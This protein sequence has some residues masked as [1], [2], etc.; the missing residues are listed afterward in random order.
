MFSE[1]AALRYFLFEVP[2]ALEPLRVLDTR[3]L[4]WNGWR[5]RLHILGASHAVCMERD[6]GQ[7]TE[8]LACIAPSEQDTP[9]WLGGAQTAWETCLVIQGL[10]CRIGLSPVA[11]HADIGLEAPYTSD[12][13][14][15]AAYPAASESDIPFTSLGW[16]ATAERLSIETLHTYPEAGHAVRTLTRFEVYKP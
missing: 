3:S 12:C 13:L 2:I 11:M 5:I 10:R 15:T 14:L 4:Q 16:H 1:L 6:G 8:L 7:L 9:L